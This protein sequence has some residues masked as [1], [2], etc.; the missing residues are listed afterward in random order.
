MYQCNKEKQYSEFGLHPISDARSAKCAKWRTSQNVT[1]PC[2]LMQ[3]S[4]E[5]DAF[6]ARM[7]ESRRPI[8]PRN[9][10]QS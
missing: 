1:K 9:K 2:L 7:S 10:R 4:E 8:Y 3:T 6:D 5:G